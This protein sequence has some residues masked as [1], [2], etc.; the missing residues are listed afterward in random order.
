MFFFLAMKEEGKEQL[1]V[2]WC[3]LKKTNHDTQQIREWMEV[4]RSKQTIVEKTWTAKRLWL[5]MK[6]KFKKR[7]ENNINVT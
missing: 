1:F 2:W 6:L 7:K 3:S 4:K 5:Q